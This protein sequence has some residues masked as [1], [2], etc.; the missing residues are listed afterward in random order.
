[1][2]CPKQIESILILDQVSPSETND[3]D[4]QLG[5]VPEAIAFKNN[6]NNN[7]NNNDEDDD[8]DDD[9][10]TAPQAPA[11]R[12]SFAQQRPLAIAG[13]E[14]LPSSA[15]FAQNYGKNSEWHPKIAKW[16][17]K[18]PNWGPHREA[19][20]K[21][22]HQNELDWDIRQNRRRMASSSGMVSWSLHVNLFVSIHTPNND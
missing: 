11:E 14:D 6:N 21:S 18:N 10:L 7:N 20:E 16:A 13:A 5:Q 15:F 1:M 22:W 8:D 2:F 17:P 19:G 9:D 12:R 4:Y 3:F